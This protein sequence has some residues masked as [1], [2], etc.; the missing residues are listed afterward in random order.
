MV[1]VSENINVLTK[2]PHDVSVLQVGEIS[3][4]EKRHHT[5][6]TTAEN[7]KKGLFLVSD[8]E[9]PDP[10]QDSGDEYVPPDS[11]E[12]ESED[13]SH[14]NPIQLSFEDC[15]E[16][17][18]RIMQSSCQALNIDREV[19]LECVCVFLLQIFLFFSRSLLPQRNQNQELGIKETTAIFAT[20]MS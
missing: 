4:T 13:D 16:S 12:S 7:Q 11:T 1:F 9:S 14:S 15:T 20:V 17:T 10:H 5:R 2:Y 18:D 19:L 6:R 8:S 3:T